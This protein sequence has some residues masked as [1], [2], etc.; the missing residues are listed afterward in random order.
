MT[1]YTMDLLQ[2]PKAQLNTEDQKYCDES[3]LWLEIAAQIETEDMQPAVSIKKLIEEHRAY[4]TIGVYQPYNEM[5]ISLAFVEMYEDNLAA[6]NNTS[7][8][9]CPKCHKNGIQLK[10]QQKRSFDE[11]T[12]ETMRCKYCH[13]EEGHS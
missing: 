10:I 9:K 6:D 12:N 13:T 7:N 1:I 5:A 3:N 2:L 4:G 8:L 11:C